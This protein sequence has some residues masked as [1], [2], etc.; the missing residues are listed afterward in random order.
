MAGRVLHTLLGR[1]PS[2]GEY[3]T[4]RDAST[5]RTMRFEI[6]HVATANVYYVAVSYCVLQRAQHGGAGELKSSTWPW[7]TC[8]S[9]R[10]VVAWHSVRSVP[11]HA[12]HATT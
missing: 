1:V 3:V 6:K 4:M 2:G 12:Q 5:D 7:P 11:Q 10:L 9:W 8:A